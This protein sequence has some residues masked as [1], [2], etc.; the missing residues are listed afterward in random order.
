MPTPEGRVRAVAM[1]DDIKK[2]L[3]RITRDAE[4]RVA[5][6]LLRW[7]YKKEGKPVPAES[8]LDGDAR[9]VAGRAHEIIENRGRR[10]W[11][12]FKKLGGKGRDGGEDENP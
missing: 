12:E 8:R 6:A 10:I 5:R 2:N 7:R 3:N 11:N 9:Q 1:G 4:A